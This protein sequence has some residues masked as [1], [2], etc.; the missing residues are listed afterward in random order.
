MTWCKIFSFFLFDAR[1]SINYS[2]SFD[3]SWVYI[4]ISFPFTLVRRIL[5]FPK[6]NNADNLSM[7]LD[8]ADSGNLP[9]GWTRHAHFSLT[10]VNQVHSKYSIKKG[11]KT[12]I[13]HLVSKW[14]N[15]FWFCTYSKYLSLPNLFLYHLGLIWLGGYGVQ[16]TA[17]LCF[18]LLH[19]TTH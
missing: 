13:I 8:V 18:N 1:A 17:Q 16:G 15:L 3:E 14:F 12:S 10:V 4:T 9:Y 11:T 19:C 5:I 7:Y 6:G 2:Q